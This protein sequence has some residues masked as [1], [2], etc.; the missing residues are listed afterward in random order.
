MYAVSCRIHEE[1]KISSPLRYVNYQSDFVDGK[2]KLTPCEPVAPAL[3]EATSVVINAL[4]GNK[5]K[6]L[7]SRINVDAVDLKEHISKIS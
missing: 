7:H 3:A 5:S 2:L 4:T 6:E 1:P